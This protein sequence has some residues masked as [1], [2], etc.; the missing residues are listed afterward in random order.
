MCFDKI[1]YDAFGSL[2]RGKLRLSSPTSDR[3]NGHA[4]FS[5]DE[6]G[7]EVELDDR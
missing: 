3:P 2:R 1:K 7:R 5:R 4:G 6:G